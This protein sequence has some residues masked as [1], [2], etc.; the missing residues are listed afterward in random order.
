MHVNNRFMSC[1]GWHA[2][3]AFSWSDAELSN[4]IVATKLTISYLDSRGSPFE[5][6]AR[7]LNL[8]LQHLE[9][10]WLARTG[11]EFDYSEID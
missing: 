1:G 10:W 6:L 8:D 5:S 3:L 4:A 2:N 9:G 11:R 7:K